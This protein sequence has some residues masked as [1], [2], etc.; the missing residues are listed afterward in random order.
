[1]SRTSGRAGQS[2]TSAAH[3][4]QASSGRFTA[5]DGLARFLRHE[6]NTL[7]IK[8]YAGAGKTTLAIQLLEE[9][10][11]KGNGV[12]VSSR[13]SRE[14]LQRE[15]PWSGFG[16]RTQP[17][18]G[19]SDLRL[20]SAASF[21][22]EVMKAVVPKGRPSPPVVVLDTWDG[23][24]KEMEAKER[25]KSEKMLIALADASKTRLVFVSE[26]PE[27]TTMDY[28]VDGIVELKREEEFGRVFREIEVQ[29]LR[30]TLIEQHKYLYTL[31]GGRFVLIP[32]YDVPP[33]SKAQ[34]PTPI[35]DRGD[36]F[37]FGSPGLDEIFEGLRK[38]GTFAAVYDEKVPYSILR[39]IAVSALVNALNVGKG[40]VA[41]PLPGSADKDL[42]EVMKPF[43]SP[44]TYR[45]CLAIASLGSDTD[46]EPPL[47]SVAAQAQKDTTARLDELVA[48][49]RNSSETKSV[50]VIESV[51]TFEAPFATRIEAV[52][53][54]IGGRAGQ[55]RSSGTDALLLLLQHDSPISS[56]ILAL[57]GKYARL[58]VK[59]RSIVITGEKPSTPAFALE[60]S[61][62][63]PLLAH[64]TL[65][66]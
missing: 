41:V 60:H 47:Y 58:F 52:L 63:N 10:A 42:A 34:A 30:G 49:V 44:K 16:T 57:S 7:L 62:E 25:L 53:E 29:K 39:L 12:Y 13:V 51:G 31:A 45:N 28:L 5:L 24:A 4:P 11:P 54:G 43:V 38:G 1:M 14:K 37:S 64:L 18:T 22:E 40:V 33:I 48:K 15:L 55:V 35:S 27:R 20:G 2:R 66:V 32:P 36:Y 65:I 61:Q 59:D 3:A 21:V 9:L 6:G 8:G 50:L 17:G 46:L 19:F 26:E 56:R 23:I